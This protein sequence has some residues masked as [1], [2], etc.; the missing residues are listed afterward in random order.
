MTHAFFK[1]LL[2]MGAGSVISALGVGGDASIDKMGGFRK[3]MPFT[4]LCFVVGGLALSGV[5]PFSGFFSKD[6]ILALMGERGGWHWALY[7]LGYLGSFLTAVYTWRMIFRAFFGPPVPEAA[8]LEGGHLHHAEVHRNPATGEEEDTDVGF[9]GAE[10]HIAERESSMKIAMVVLMIGATVLGFLQIPFHTTNVIHDFL[11][12]T[13]EGSKYYEGLDPSDSFT[14]LGLVIGAVLGIAGI[15][16][17]YVIWVR[18]TGSS[19]RIQARLAPVHRLFV[20]KWY[21]DELLDTVIVRPFAWFG[22]FGIQTFERAVIQGGLMGGTTSL[23]RAGSATVR[24]LQS[25]LLRS[26]AALLILGTLGVGLYFL[27]Q[28]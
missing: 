3:A 18:R 5:P 13:F 27:V 25:G 9:P 10:H 4:V 2:F 1:A 24:A 21:F 20:N 16:L 19:A 15:A 17:A 7:G 6:E 8:E 12:P 28:S 11:A 23:V 26:Y 14:M 22:R